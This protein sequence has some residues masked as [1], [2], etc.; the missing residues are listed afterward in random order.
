[1]YYYNILEDLWEVMM[2][3]LEVKVKERKYSN[4]GEKVKL[5]NTI[6][7]RYMLVISTLILLFSMLQ[8]F[9]Q[10]ESDVYEYVK[11]GFTL[12]SIIVCFIISRRKSMIDKVKYIVPLSFLVSYS[13]MIIF[14][15]NSFESLYIV[16]IL[17]PCIS[18]FDRKLMKILIGLVAITNA[19]R[20]VRFSNTVTENTIESYIF[21]IIILTLLLIAI[22]YVSKVLY[23]FNHDA[24]S[25]LEEE[26]QVGEYMLKDVLQI[27][28]MVQ[29]GTTEVGKLV[30]ELEQSTEVV[31][32]SVLG[33]S[34]SA[35][36]TA[37]NIQEQTIMTQ[38][39]QEAITETSNYTQNI[40]GIAEQSSHAVSD[41]LN[42]ML[43]LKEQSGSIAKTNSVVMDSMNTLQGR[44]KEVQEIAK[45]IFD[46]SSKT[47][48]LALNASI[49]SAR[50][51]EAGKGF[52][53]VADQIRELAEQTRKS[54]E[55][56]TVIVDELNQNAI[57]ATTTVQESIHATENQGKLIET[58]SS[59]FEGISSNIGVLTDDINSIG[60]MIS[61]LLNSN[62]S[63]VDNISQISAASEEVLA[64]SQE[65][66]EM[67]KRNSD[68][69][70][71]SKKL[72]DEVIG[73]SHKLDK[74]LKL[75]T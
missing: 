69:V 38:S 2:D 11:V 53:V 21:E 66:T 39:I 55:E 15:Y 68:H 13:F 46:I 14:N 19:I 40:V 43:E 7:V 8:I 17:I 50:A 57:V 51:G 6:I 56:I 27:A 32:N 41:N 63:I 37:E 47:N 59:N 31:H 61:G 5:A 23:R 24:M 25:T 34:K 4:K 9:V 20:V 45:L 1:M 67:S 62:N 44:T 10:K 58:A 71:E 42:L 35:Q 64:E 73:T 54:M 30:D 29:E 36:L 18:Y 60:T 33:I 70:E 3:N 49:E 16:I 74:Y 72:L 52:A 75:N 65:V 48:L 22:Y 28:G 26:K 12:I